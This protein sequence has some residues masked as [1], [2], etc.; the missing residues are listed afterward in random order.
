MKYITQSF[1]RLEFLKITKP[2]FMAG[3]LSLFLFGISSCGGKKE[4]NEASKPKTS[5]EVTAKDILGNKAYPAISYGGYRHN[6]REEQPSVEELKED[7]KLLSA[8]GI[9]VL[10]TYNVHLPHASNLLRAIRQLRQE[11]AG[12]EMYVMLGAWID[13]KNAWT[14]LEPDHNQESERNAVEIEKAAALSNEYPDIVKV[15]AVGNEA[16]VRWA[17]SYYVQPSVILKWVT[18]LQEM[19]KNGELPADL[20]IT[21]SDDFASWGGGDPSYH[22]QDLEKLIHAVDYISM[23][24]YPYHNSHYNPEFWVL[25]D[26]TE[27]D[28]DMDK[29]DAAMARARDFAKAQYEAVSAHVKRVGADKPIHIGETGWATVSNGHYG[30]KGSRATDQYKQAL[31]YR[32]M[33][34]WTG[35]AGISCFYFEAFDEP[36]KDAHNKNGSENHFGLFTVDGKAKFV[37]WDL[38]DKGVFAGMTRNGN[39]ITKT[40]DGDKDTLMNEVLVPPTREEQEA[41]PK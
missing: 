12:F 20:W 38:V 33:R 18:H 37:I 32:H 9:R 39:P 17:T 28:P 30:P 31:Y 40:Y 21:S 26:G 10:R 1:E 23:H 13:C 3:V 24:T 5:T 27:A 25:P 34:E 4:K 15:L 16:M 2:L 11:D 41:L 14:D 29:V 7:M 36:W 22:T 8:M 35:Q 6:T 19:K